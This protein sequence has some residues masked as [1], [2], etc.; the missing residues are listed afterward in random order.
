VRVIDRTY[1]HLVLGFATRAR[2]KLEACASREADT[3]AIMLR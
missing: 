3:Q 2:E 1:G